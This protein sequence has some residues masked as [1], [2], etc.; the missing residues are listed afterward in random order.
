M[1]ILN[2]PMTYLAFGVVRF[3]QFILALTVCGLYGVDV[4][5]MRKAHVHTDGRWAYAIVVGTFS[6]ITALIYLIP[7]TMRKMS[8]LFVWDVLL[9]F[10]WIV[11][12]GI[13]GKLFIKEDAE[14]NKDIQR[15]KNAVWVDLINMLLWLATSISVGIYWFKH[16]HNRSQF[17]GRAVV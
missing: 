13:F 14:G 3:I 1:A 9:L 10:F 12:F 17:T 7:V 6:A 15:M 4:T 8:I 11:L 16:R 5:S 2:E